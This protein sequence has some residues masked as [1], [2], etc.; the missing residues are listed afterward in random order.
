M[1]ER[2]DGDC[3]ITISSKTLQFEHLK[4]H[5]PANTNSYL[6]IKVF[7][8]NGTVSEKYGRLSGQVKSIRLHISDISCIPNLHKSVLQ[9]I[10]VGASIPKKEAYT[11]AED[12][13]F[14]SLSSSNSNFCAVI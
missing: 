4:V 2:R 7:K 12:T 13:G 3:G 1:D 5:H 6:D 10:L 8:T 9:W 11:E 14:P